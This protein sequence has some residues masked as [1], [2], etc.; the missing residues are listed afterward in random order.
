MRILWTVLIVAML[1]II[2]VLPRD[3]SLAEIPR[4]VAQSG[5]PSTAPK[6]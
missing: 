3:F 5:T 2:V 4:L 1:A 6:I